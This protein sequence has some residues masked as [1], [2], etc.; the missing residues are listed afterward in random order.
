V[1]YCSGELVI[2]SNL[3][4]KFCLLKTSKSLQREFAAVAHLADGQGN[5]GKS[6]NF[7]VGSRKHTMSKEVGK[8][9]NK[10]ALMIK[11]L[12]NAFLLPRKMCKLS[13]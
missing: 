8:I 9:Q 2:I 4:V 1:T 12:S 11:I 6:R 5:K 13:I 3:S 7:R 10:N